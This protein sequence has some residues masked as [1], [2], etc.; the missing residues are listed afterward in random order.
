M[1]FLGICKLHG[2]FQFISHNPTPIHDQKSQG[3][4]EGRGGVEGKKDNT[5]IG[6]PV[7]SFL[8]S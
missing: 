5:N 1:S 2:K 8:Q 7:Q 3:H 6:G 4:W